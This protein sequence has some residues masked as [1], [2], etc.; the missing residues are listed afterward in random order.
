MCYPVTIG[1]PVYRALDYISETIESVLKQTYPNIELLIVDDCGNDGSMEIISH[2]KAN[3]Y[4]GNAIRILRNTHN[5]GVGFSRNRI[6]DEAQGKYLYFM[7]SDD[8]IEPDTIQLLFDSLSH[9]KAEVAYASY[10]IVDQVNYHHKKVYKKETMLFSKCNELAYYVFRNSGIFHVSVC[11][12]LF[13]I[14]FLR[15][16]GVRFINTQFWEDLVFTYEF[17]PKVCRTVLLSEVTYHYHR[18][19]ESLSHYQNRDFYE[20]QEIMN[21]AST[22]NYIKKKCI[23][24]KGKDYLPY[25]C[26]NIEVNSFYI[27]CHIMRHF[28]NIIPEIS[29]KEMHGIIAH[30]LRFLDILQ[31]RHKCFTNF[32]FWLLGTMPLVLFIPSV[33]FLCMIKSLSRIIK[34]YLV[35][36]K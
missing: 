36:N 4:R 27:V 31:F 9:H 1:I 12:C 29:Y 33:W 24:Y 10:E 23:E 30:P 32:L 11:N 22:L 3:H 13:D 25:M 14:L 21:N 19:A 17:V 28:R 26:Y 35:F 8:T 15:Q 20:K 2:M 5:M 7:D 18:R 34:D 16:T 6:I